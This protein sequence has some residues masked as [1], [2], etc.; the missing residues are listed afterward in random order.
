L[1]KILIL[2]AHPRPDRSEINIALADAVKSHEAVTFIDLYA[3]YP[4]L[5]FDVDMEQAR[6]IEHDVIIFQHPVFWYSSPAIIKEWQDLVLEYGF[7]YGTAGHALEGKILLNAVTGGADP[8]AY[9]P[10]GAFQNGLRQLFAP[11]EQTA[12]LCGMRYLPPFA[13]FGS[14]H[15]REQGRLEVHTR[16]YL[17][18]INALACDEIDP[19]QTLTLQTLPEPLDEVINTRKENV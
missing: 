2:F 14:G 17:R 13:L 8:E 11:F 3:E 15:A 9:G 18:L 5:D 6:L 10:K 1:K 16:S 4:D 12:R 7:A 19:A